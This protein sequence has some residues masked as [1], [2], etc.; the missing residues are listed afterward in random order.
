MIV[1]IKGRD[2]TSGS[3]CC[4]IPQLQPVQ[5]RM[6][7][8]PQPAPA[9]CLPD[10]ESPRARHFA[11]G[12]IT[13]MEVERRALGCVQHD[14]HVDA[15]SGRGRFWLSIRPTGACDLCYK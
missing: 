10:C 4:P 12:E 6:H 13:I 8:R 2:F 5:Q 14:W 3:S 15:A 9:P 7:C 1:T 11:F